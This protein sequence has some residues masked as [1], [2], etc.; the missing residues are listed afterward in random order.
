MTRAT[1]VFEA[2]TLHVAKRGWRNEMQSPKGATHP[3]RT[4]SAMVKAL[5]RGYRWKKMLEL[6]EFATVAELAEQERIEPSTGPASC[7]SRC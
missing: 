1:S 3:L 7:A 2:A 6:D 4:N 5:A